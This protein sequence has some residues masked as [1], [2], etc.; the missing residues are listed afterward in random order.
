MEISSAKGDDK[1]V[2]L[3]QKVLEGK[4]HIG[5]LQDYYCDILAN[6]VTADLILKSLSGDRLKSFKLMS[7]A[8]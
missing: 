6:N 5:W 2:G 1:C 4:N 7:L 8:E 3:T